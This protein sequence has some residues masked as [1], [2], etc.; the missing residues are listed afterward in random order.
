[1]AVVPAFTYFF[2]LW[3]GIEAKILWLKKFPPE[4]RKSCKQN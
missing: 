2:T 1:M 3:K 4:L